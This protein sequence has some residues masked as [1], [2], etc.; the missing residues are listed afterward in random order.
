[1]GIDSRSF[2]KAFTDVMRFKISK[3]FIYYNGYDL[4]LDVKFLFTNL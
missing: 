3:L 1:M 4:I 2:T